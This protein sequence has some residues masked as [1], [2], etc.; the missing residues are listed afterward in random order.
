MIFLTGALFL[1]FFANSLG[2]LVAGYVLIGLPLGA[3]QIAS[4]VF[5]SEVCPIRLRP[6]L[7]CWVCMSWGVSGEIEA[8]SFFLRGLTLRPTL[9]SRL[10]C[11]WQL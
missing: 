11:F 8:M 10:E 7:T 9:N 4:T 5:A 3:F 1:L 6:Y 2:M